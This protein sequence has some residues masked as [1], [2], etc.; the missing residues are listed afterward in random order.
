MTLN[1]VKSQTC[2]H[3][4]CNRKKVPHCHQTIGKDKQMTETKDVKCPLCG[5][6]TKDRDEVFMGEKFTYYTC[7]NSGCGL[8]ATGILPEQIELLNSQISAIKKSAKA[9]VFAELEFEIVEVAPDT[10]GL[11]AILGIFEDKYEQLKEKHIRGNDQP[12]QGGGTP[13]A[14]IGVSADGKGKE[15]RK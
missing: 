5:G 7:K 3:S 2:P 14:G 13:D 15:G 1:E 6:E 10:D 12:G 4:F 11:G 8:R 9:E